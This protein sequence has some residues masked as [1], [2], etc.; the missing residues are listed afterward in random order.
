V[1]EAG[2]DNEPLLIVDDIEHAIVTH[3][4]P[5]LILETDQLPTTKWPR[6]TLQLGDRR[7]DPIMNLRGK[8]SEITPRGGE[9]GN[10]IGTQ[11]AAV[12]RRRR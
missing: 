11:R 3:S 12:L 5:P 4:Q 7:F 10:G 6:I 2:D 1:G 8:P 9:K